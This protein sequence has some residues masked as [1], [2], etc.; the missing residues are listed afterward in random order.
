VEVIGL[1]SAAIR[2][3]VPAQGTDAQHQEMQRIPARGMEARD[4]AALAV[5]AGA[6][7]FAGSDYENGGWT[8]S[9]GPVLASMEYAD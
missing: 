5:V 3:P 6:H 8:A 7:F 1:D 9:Y 2:I 4:F